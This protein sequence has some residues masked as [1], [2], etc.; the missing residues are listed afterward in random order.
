MAENTVVTPKQSATTRKNYDNAIKRLEKA[1]LNLSDSDAVCTHISGLEQSLHSKKLYYQALGAYF[2]SSN[3]ALS[4]YYI[5]KSK[6]LSRQIKETAK[7]QCLTPVERANYLDY[8]SICAVYDR[9]TYCQHVSGEDRLLVGFYTQMPPVRADYSELRIFDNSEPNMEFNHI[10]IRGDI[11]TDE[12]IVTVRIAEHKT[13]SSF[14]ILERVLPA[15][16]R[17]NLAEYMAGEEAFYGVKPTWLFVFPPA[18]ITT[19]LNKVFQIATGKAISVNL[20]RH[21]YVTKQTEGRP[22]LAQLEAEAQEMGHSVMTHEMYRR[23]DA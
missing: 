5:Q 22:P 2:K 14:G 13:A 19:R 17:R 10:E 6:P 4:E 15:N 11:D 1:G 7:G 18:H 16:L 21:A 23:L 8:D 3:L 20:I 9:L 12:C